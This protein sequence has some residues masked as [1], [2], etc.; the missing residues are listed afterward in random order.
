MSSPRTVSW[1]LLRLQPY[2]SSLPTKGDSIHLREL[3]GETQ[4]KQ[5]ELWII[6]MCSDNDPFHHASVLDSGFSVVIQQSATSL[7]HVRLR[8][9]FFLPAVPQ[10]SELLYF[11]SLTFHFPQA[12]RGSTDEN[13]C[14]QNGF[15]CRL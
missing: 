14:F 15:P 1:Q 3:G 5:E 11:F 10:E 7:H 12:P 9:F 4:G 6:N 13:G 2:S 8:D